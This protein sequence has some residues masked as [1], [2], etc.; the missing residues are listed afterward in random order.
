MLKM[1]VKNLFRRKTRTLLTMLGI[2]VGVSMIVALGAMAEGIRT[3]YQSMFSGS[4]SDLT[5]MQKGA[6]DITLS[7]VDEEVVSQIAA[8]PEV[9]EVTGMVVGNVAAADAPYFFVFG[10][11]PDGFAIERFRIVEGQPLSSSRRPAA[12]GREIIVGKQASEA[13]K[14]NVGDTVRITGGTFNVVGIYNSGSGFEDAAAI[15]SL[16]DAQQLL[17]KHRQVGA[18]QVK[19]KDARQSER[20]R[21]Q[22]ERLYPRLAA[23]QSSQTAD[24]QQ[25]TTYIQGF[26]VAI[27]LLAVIIGGVGMAN[28]AMMSTF[29][30]T[31]EIGTLRALGWSRR[32]VLGMVFGENLALG[33]AGGLLG[34]ALGAAMIALL[35]QSAALAFVQGQVT[36]SLVGQGLATALILGAVGGLY[37]ARWASRLLPVEA[38]S[39]HGGSAKGS[40]ARLT[41][42]RSETLRSLLRRRTRTALTVVGIGI[43]LSAVVLLSGLADGFII[44]F[45]QMMA[46]TDMDLVVRQAEATDFSYSAIS[47]RDGR[48]IAALPGVQSVSGIVIGAITMEE[49]PFLLVFG[50]APHE[51]AIEHFRIVEGRSL[52]GSR[53]MILGRAAADAMKVRVGDIVRMSEVGFRVVGIF[54]TSMSIEDSGG[55]IPLRDAQALTG[56]PRQVSM[57]GVKI[58]DPGQAESIQAQIEASVP[59]VAVSPSSEFAENLPDLQA[60]YA[61]VWAISG[62]AI[63]VGGI[64]MMNTM[65]MSIYERTREIGALRALGWR[66]RRVL[67]M[68][69]RESLALSLVGALAGILLAAVFSA[70]L[71]LIPLWGEMLIVTFSPGLLAQ[72]LIVA[73]VLGMLGGLYP[74]WR[75]SNLRPAEALRYE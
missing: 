70:L 52:S 10:Y 11:D 67:R 75:A 12:S 32:R 30:R 35:A 3:G 25:M 69:L 66:R 74:A 49:M 6:Y 4:G 28:T 46:G 36:P 9:R 43:G 59:G 42:L 20:V 62:L 14:L 29:E 21:A 18:V 33:L 41:R 53:E 72:A 65:V 71:S 23:S 58:V 61:M 64:G 5:L 8:M 51:P 48:K 68:V 1:I 13:L 55:V 17:Q 19:L 16:S 15:L 31:R 56:K 22:L 54:E 57:Y 27:A 45:N 73:A 7:G 24:Q 34:C 50:Y 47:E 26:A 44:I 37:P 38:L 60:T 2:A 40:G 63:L 39:Y